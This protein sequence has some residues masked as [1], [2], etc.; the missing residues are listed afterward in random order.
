MSQ[1]ILSRVMNFHNHLSPEVNSYREAANYMSTFLQPCP[2]PVWSRHLQQFSAAGFVIL[3]CQSFYLLFVRSKEKKFYQIG[4]N[5][6]GLIQLDRANHCG[7]SYFFYGIAAFVDIVF[8]EA[9]EAGRLDQAWPNLLLGLKC[10]LTI[11]CAVVIPWLCI[12][13]FALI[14]QRGTNASKSP[15][16]QRLP[17]TVVWGLN[18]LLV[19]LILLPIIT[20]LLSFLEVTV[21]YLRVEHAVIPVIKALHKAASHFSPS[22]NNVP[23]LIKIVFT[24]A[25][26]LSHVDLIWKYI[27]VGLTFYLIFSGLVFLTY[28][29]FIVQLFRFYYLHRQGVRDF[30]AKQQKRILVNTLL[31]FIL[32]SLLASLTFYLYHITRSGDFMFNPR[33]W[34]T[35]RAMNGIISVLGNA[36]VFLILSS[37]LGTKSNPP[38]IQE[39]NETE[40]KGNSSTD[41]LTV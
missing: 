10:T 6:L 36:A 8:E 26:A 5:H 1:V 9:A 12:C 23:K 41:K 24:A 30:T 31:E 15:G 17:K 39:D 32:T 35:M 13:H 33:F 40:M 20:I 16:G 7:L 38:E 11:T 19:I 21:E 28:I 3:I 37:L 34:L 29:P 18:G 27:Q 22:T 14:R 2:L 25:P 4:F